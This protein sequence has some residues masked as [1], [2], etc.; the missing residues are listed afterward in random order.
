[1]TRFDHP[2]WQGAR[3]GLALAAVLLLAL[4][5]AG[6]AAGAASARTVAHW[7]M[8]EHAAAKVLRDSAHHYNGRIGRRVT[9]G[10]GFHHFGFVRRGRVV[11]GHVDV[12][13]D[14]DNL[15]PGA[16][17]LAVTVTFRWPR[18][19]RD[20]N[21]IQKGQSGASGGLFKMKTNTGPKEP[22]GVIRCLYRG[23][24]GDSTVSSF[25]HKRLDDGRWHTVRCSEDRRGTYE[26]VDGRRVDHNRNVPGPIRNDWPVAIG[27]N[28]YC[29][30][31]KGLQC[32]Y[33]HGDI[34]DVRW[35]LS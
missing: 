17:H 11:D 32:N 34:G 10:H 31:S 13:P 3:W 8:N 20:N 6:V 23:A 4:V 27:G 26:Y 14:Y 12:V 22:P 5:A 21:L 7:R 18:G 1:M 9:P 29:P 24:F 25:G 2:F 15:D 30:H 28:T 33:W 35:A 19:D 16:D